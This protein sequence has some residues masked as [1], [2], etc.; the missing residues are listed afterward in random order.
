MKI[1]PFEFV[2]GHYY[3]NLMHATQDTFTSLFTKQST[4]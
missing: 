2:M 1:V 4:P 3:D